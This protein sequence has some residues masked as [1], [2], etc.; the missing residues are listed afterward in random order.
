MVWVLDGEIWPLFEVGSAGL[1]SS[2][3]EVTLFFL[4]TNR[5]LFYPSG[6]E[7]ETASLKM[8]AA[9]LLRNAGTHLGTLFLNLFTNFKNFSYLVLIII[10]LLFF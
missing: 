8:Q 5:F 6:S 4:E 7:R 2:L 3:D 10:V 9:R 1:L